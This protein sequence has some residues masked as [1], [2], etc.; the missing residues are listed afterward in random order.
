MTT[1]TEMIETVRRQLDGLKFND[2]TALA[3]RLRLVV[4]G[5]DSLGFDPNRKFAP[6][7]KVNFAAY[8][9]ATWQAGDVYMA[10]LG[11]EDAKAPEAPE[12]PVK[13][14]AAKPAPTAPVD[15]GSGQQAAIAAAIGSALGSIKFGLQDSEV[16]EIA[17]DVAKSVAKDTLVEAGEIA[18]KAAAKAIAE[19]TI[20]R[21]I[22]VIRKEPDGSQKSTELGVQ[23]HMFDRLLSRCNLRTP[24]GNRLNL[25]MTGPAGSGK[26]TAA[27]NVAKALGLQFAF[28]GAIDS[29]YKLL[30]FT[31]AQG[32]VVS[33]PFRKA[34]EEGGVYLFDEVDASLPGAVLAFNAAL[35]NGECD[36]PDKC[37]TRH[38]DCVIIAAANTWGSGATS[39]YVGR[40]QQDKAFL[41]RFVP[42]AWDYDEALETAISGNQKWS[43]TVQKY[44]AAVAKL[45]MK[46]AV[47]PRAS[48]YGAVLLAAGESEVDVIETLIRR[49]MTDDQWMQVRSA[50]K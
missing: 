42:M 32:R 1:E 25:W 10:M 30:G 21:P 9:M 27:K 16:R 50:A 35:A 33:R 46:H 2:L 43:R 11:S 17:Q 31:D 40:M 39:E 5:A 14:V 6:P 41:D 15:T 48:M 22:V 4:D 23:H 45:G 7:M 20:P 3:K 13:P 26:T 19:A 49:G 24:D 38:P 29:E 44:R 37:V 47:T 28:N 8:I 34:Y 12:K 36:F 18:H